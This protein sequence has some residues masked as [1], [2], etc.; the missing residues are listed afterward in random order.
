MSSVGSEWPKVRANLAVLIER[1]RELGPA[2]SFGLAVLEDLAR[3]AD[4]AWDKQDL[5]ELLPLFD[6]MRR[7]E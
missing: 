1:Y 6:E 5:K 2:G 7:A 4:D 3:R